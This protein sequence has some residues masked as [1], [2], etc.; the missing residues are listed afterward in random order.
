MVLEHKEGKMTRQ[1]EVL[2]YKEDGQ[3]TVAYHGI[4]LDKYDYLTVDEFID[5][6]EN[7]DMWSD[8]DGEVYAKALDEYDLDYYSYEDPDTM[9]S[10]FLKA[11][12]A[13]R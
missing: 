8:I 9:W 1:L 2:R 11:V 13:D 6:V 4:D 7:T 3:I 5:E 10:D 12:K